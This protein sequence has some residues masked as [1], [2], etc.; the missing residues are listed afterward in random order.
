[1]SRSRNVCCYCFGFGFLPRQLH[2]KV[3]WEGLRKT[4][5]GTKGTRQ[6]AVDKLKTVSLPGESLLP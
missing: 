3:D 4:A 6:V 5:L 1:M 2:F